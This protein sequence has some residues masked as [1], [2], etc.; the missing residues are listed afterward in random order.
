[1]VLISES[2]ELEGILN[3][4]GVAKSS[5]ELRK[6][7]FVFLRNKELFQ[8]K[9]Y[10]AFVYLQRATAMQKKSEFDFSSFATQCL[11]FVRICS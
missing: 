6:E 4:P 11:I 8:G 3:L 9:T 10:T 2:S 7:F 5:L 1:M